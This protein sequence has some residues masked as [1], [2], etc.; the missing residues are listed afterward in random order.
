MIGGER[1]G[2]NAA[3]NGTFARPQ[4]AAYDGGQPGRCSMSRDQFV[5]AW[6]LVSF[7]SKLPDGTV[8]HPFGKAPV[9]LVIF[10]PGGHVAAQ[11]MRPDRPRFASGEQGT[12]TP[13]EIRQAF[14]GCVA[15]FGRCEVDEGAR[16]L[17]THVEGSLL[18]NWIGGDQVRTYEF[19]GDRLVLRPPTRTVEGRT[20]TSELI[21]ERA[22]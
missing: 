7:E 1:P 2:V 4:G 12:G 8:R 20:I 16:T 5:G 22:G 10:S 6:R 11:L 18:P 19:R 9:G 14:S 15:Y 3:C 13:D 17:V 21:W